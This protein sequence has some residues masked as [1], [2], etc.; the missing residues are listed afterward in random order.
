[1]GHVL[2]VFELGQ[3]VIHSLQ[4][5]RIMFQHRGYRVGGGLDIGKA[6]Q[7]RHVRLG[8][9][10]QA[11]LSPQHRDQRA[12]AAD[13]KFG[14]VESRLGQQRIEVVS[15]DAARDVGVA[16][17]HLFAVVV[18]Q[19][20]QCPIDFAAAVTFGD[21]ARVVVVVGGAHPHADPVVG[22][23][24]HA[25]DGIDHLSV[26]LR[27]RPA[28]VVADHPADRAADVGGRF[29]PDHPSRFGQRVVEFVELDAGLHG[30]DARLGVDRQHAGAV[31]APVQ[32]HRDVAGLPRQT[33]SPA[34]REHWNV[35]VVADR[36]RIGRGL[37]GARDDDTE[38]NLAVVGGIGRVGG[39]GTEIESDLAVHSFAQGVFQLVELL[40]WAC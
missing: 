3:P 13:E 12:L 38:G 35:V 18:P 33:G 1:M 34:S 39:P 10:H 40:L 7:H 21:D 4:R 29:R 11:D 27:G 31:L 26:R 22:Q 28:R 20:A 14:D 24:L 37:R 2:T 9:P 25:P 15:G 30:G 5:G 19:P 32:H 6:E 8:H 23:H 36:Y 16:G 17:A